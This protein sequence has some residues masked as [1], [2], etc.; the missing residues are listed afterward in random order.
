MNRCWGKRLVS[1]WCCLCRKL[2]N[3]PWIQKVFQWSRGRLK[4]Q[5][6]VVQLNMSFICNILELTFWIYKNVKSTYLKKLSSAFHYL[7]MHHFT[8]PENLIFSLHHLS[9]SIHTRIWWWISTAQL[10]GMYVIF[11][12]CFGRQKGA[13]FT[14]NLTLSLY[15]FAHFFLFFFSSR[16]IKD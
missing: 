8:H 13:Y 5:I 4:L 2:F 15:L 6:S 10:Y 12:M 9:T 1:C 7:N 11:F 16:C 3:L 14:S